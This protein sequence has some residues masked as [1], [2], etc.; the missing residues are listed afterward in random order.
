ME[1]SRFKE[2]GVCPV[3]RGP[4]KRAGTGIVGGVHRHVMEFECGLI[5][6]EESIIRSCPESTRYA[7]TRAM[8]DL[9]VARYGN[10][11][12]LDRAE[13]LK[14]SED[15][16]AAVGRDRQKLIESAARA[17]WRGFVIDGAIER[18]HNPRECHALTHGPYPWKGWP[19][20][21]CHPAMEAR[22]NS[23]APSIK[24]LFISKATDATH[25]EFELAGAIVRLLELV[26][27]QRV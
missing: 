21:S 22:W 2:L 3:C 10:V 17:L 15:L 16:V 26:R 25:L 1:S 23:V 24:A 7:W 18:L 5:L 27:G 11:V 4:L 13:L 12:D 6:G 19:C 20:K 8:A 9:E 14:R